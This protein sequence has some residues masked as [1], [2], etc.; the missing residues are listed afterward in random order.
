MTQ[1]TGA[2]GA[3]LGAT[4]NGNYQIHDHSP[5]SH[6]CYSDLVVNHFMHMFC[7]HGWQG[8]L[9]HAELLQTLLV[10]SLIPNGRV[11]QAP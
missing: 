4:D 8:V 10:N 9:T 1:L 6:N 5:W 2:S 11:S 3:G 7:T